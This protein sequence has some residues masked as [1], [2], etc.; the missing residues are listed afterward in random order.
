MN[1]P[2]YT[3]LQKDP[4][5]KDLTG[6][7]KMNLITRITKMDDEGQNL[8]YALIKT[9]YLNNETSSPFILPYGGRFSG[10]A[11]SYD[12]SD[13]PI[14]LRR[15]LYRFSKIH[16]KKIKEDEKISKIQ[17]IPFRDESLSG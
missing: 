3:S 5:T 4:S 11:I 15:L 13:L 14:K 8:T 6:I 17:Q 2:L 10:T 16:C 12:L 9:Y 1:F 7:Q